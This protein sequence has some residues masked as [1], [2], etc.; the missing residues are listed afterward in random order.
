MYT[1]MQ[2][3]II[4]MWDLV[5]TPNNFFE[6]YKMYASGNLTF[7]SEGRKCV[8]KGGFFHNHHR[9]KEADMD[10]NRE[11]YEVIFVKTIS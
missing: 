1:E 7:N 4:I 8:L 10:D 3:R 5:Q 2:G 6:I 9:M 11:Y